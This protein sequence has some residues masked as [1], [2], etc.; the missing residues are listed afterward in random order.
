MALARAVSELG[1]D[2]SNVYILSL[3]TGHVKRFYPA[4]DLTTGVE[5]NW[6]MLYWGQKL[7]STIWF[8][9]IEKTNDICRNLIGDRFFRID[10]ELTDDV[11]FDNPESLLQMIYYGQNAD[12]SACF[13]WLQQLPPNK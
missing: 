3:S 10:P 7:L 5:H 9:M 6:G 13:T 8:G 11:E 1:Q 4:D 12:L 2:L